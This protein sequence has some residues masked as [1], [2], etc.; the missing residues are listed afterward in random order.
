MDILLLTFRFMYWIHWG[1]ASNNIMSAHMSHVGEERL[2]IEVYEPKG[3]AIDYSDQSP[4]R[5]LFWADENGGKGIIKKTNI[6]K[7]IW[8]T[9]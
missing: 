2:A 7:V 3:M 4:D 9:L 8:N 5:T 6:V 1:V